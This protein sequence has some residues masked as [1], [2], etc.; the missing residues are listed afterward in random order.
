MARSEGASTALHSPPLPMAGSLS[1][2]KQPW[3]RTRHNTASHSSQLGATAAAEL[4]PHSDLDLLLVHDC[5]PRK[6]PDEIEPLASCTL[7]PAVGRRREA[8]SRGYVGSTN[9]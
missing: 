7:V 5:K 9:N 8:W 1:Y 2:S 4:A 3:R 6:V